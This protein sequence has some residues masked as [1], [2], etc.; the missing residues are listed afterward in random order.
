VILRLRY[1]LADKGQQ[2][3]VLL[4]SGERSEHLDNRRR[5]RNE[6]KETSQVWSS[7]EISTNKPSRMVNG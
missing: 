4:S 3:Y 1:C 2:T 6:E 5:R 7:E